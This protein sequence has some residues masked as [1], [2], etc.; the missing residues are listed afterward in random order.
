[1]TREVVPLL[2]REDEELATKRD[3][4]ARQEAQLVEAELSL[5]SLKAELAAFR[6]LY[7]RRVGVLYA[8]LDEWKAR[9]AECRAERAATPELKSKAVEARA[10]AEESYSEAYSE[11]AETP[12]FTPSEELRRLYTE[13]AAR[14]HQ[15]SGA[16]ELDRIRRE[17]LMVEIN[18]AYTACDE[19]WLQR[20]LA[21]F[22]TDSMTVQRDGNSTD[23]ITLQSKLSQY[24]VRRATI[25]YEM[26]SLKTSEIAL[27]RQDAQLSQQDAQDLLSEIAVVV[28]GQIARAKEEY[29]DQAPRVS[30]DLKSQLIKD[31][32][33]PASPDSQSLCI[34]KV[35]LNG[36]WG[37]LSADGRF[38]VSPRF[39]CLG[40]F[41][42]ERASFSYSLN[43][44]EGKW[45]YLN[46]DGEEI[47]PE[48]FGPAPTIPNGLVHWGFVDGLALVLFEGRFGYI[49][50]DGTFA[51]KP[52]YED[53]RPF[54]KG[55][56]PV[57]LDGKFFFIDKSGRY[58]GN[59]CEYIDHWQ[60]FRSKEEVVPAQLEKKWG[61]INYQGDF[62]IDPIYDRIEAT[63]CSNIWSAF[64]EK[65]IDLFDNHGQIAS[66]LLRDQYWGDVI[67]Y[68]PEEKL[69][70]IEQCYSTSDES[71]ARLILDE[72]GN[73]IVCEG[74]CR[75]IGVFRDG[76][77][78]VFEKE[79]SYY[80]NRRGERITDASLQAIGDFRFGKGIVRREAL[81]G[82]I[83]NKGNLLTP[84]HFKYAHGFLD[85]YAQALTLDGE[86]IW[87]D[88]SGNVVATPLFRE[89]GKCGLG[90]EAWPFQ[91]PEQSWSTSREFKEG[92][93]RVELDGKFGFVDTRCRI[94][95]EPRYDEVRDFGGGVAAVKDTSG[96]WGYVNKAG[97]VITAPRFDE[98]RD[99]TDELAAVK[100]DRG[101]WGY[102]NRT[103]EITVEP[104]FDAVG[105]FS[106]GLAAVKVVSGK[107]GYM[108]TVGEI[109]IS[110]QYD[111]AGYF[112]PIK[113]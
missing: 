87:I 77:C 81:Y 1:M 99:F 34:A 18:A 65:K 49:A 25:K 10:Q 27:L 26:A 103:G 104:K 63:E 91:R 59:A 2:S 74:D 52:V 29:D 48:Q 98:V 72:N 55:A 19:D 13:A 7:L 97:N 4:P 46:L 43:Y 83:D 82:Y 44:D 21:G 47:I 90:L 107:W 40:E 67:C 5:A 93:C 110:P 112:R 69:I 8:E 53:A 106:N 108:N 79:D 96:K 9:L 75:K 68:D 78:P 24:Q 62:I 14:V 12:P 95:V 76:A 36:K 84:V 37:Y 94:V 51:V 80:I 42:C 54:F 23:L 66:H 92:F 60:T 105:Y 102:I 16:D 32:P 109:V 111:Y 58:I 45:G 56:A 11:A 17:L 31:R 70:E 88:G 41:S 64:L 30:P 73:R 20:I 113:R 100:D 50:T 85:Q 38:N 89:N 61:F 86:W 39:G 28:R 101:K 22:K 35:K 3:E 15:G 33:N 6:G 71:P 57:K